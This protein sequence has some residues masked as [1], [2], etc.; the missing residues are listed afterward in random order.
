MTKFQVWYSEK[1]RFSIKFYETLDYLAQSGVMADYLSTRGALLAIIPSGRYFLH[2]PWL[3]GIIAT[4][5]HSALI[6]AIG[7]IDKGE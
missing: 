3:Q 7:I 2:A 5:Y 6:E 4:D 1:Y